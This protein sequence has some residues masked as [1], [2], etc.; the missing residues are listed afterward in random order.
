MES[1]FR[2][3]YS[4]KPEDLWVYTMVNIYRSFLGVCNLV[5][6]VSMILVAVRFWSGGSLGIRI[7]ISAGIL[8][9]P[10][11]QPLLIYFRCR[12]IVNRMPREMEIL[13][14][15]TGITTSANGESAHVNFS[16]V[17]SVVRILNLMIIYTQSKQGYILNDRVMEDK[18]KS[19]FNFI[20]TK[21]NGGDKSS[22]SR[23]S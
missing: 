16:E 3:S 2:F 9:Y 19:V 10:V 20:I 17:K 13:F 8:L 15:K 22:R 6:A 23:I 7:L 4:V 1:V 5:F 14:D 11:L 21:V 18:S 12:R